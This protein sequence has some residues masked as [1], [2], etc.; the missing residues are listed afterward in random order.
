M[1]NTTQLPL[2]NLS[3]ITATPSA[4]KALQQT[5]LSANTLLARHHCGDW[6]DLCTEDLARNNDALTSGSRLFSAYQVTDTFKI[7][8]ITEADQSAITS[9]CNIV[10][11]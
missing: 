1:K 10:M 2:F 9:I 8:V 5:G 3:Q 6:G 11:L 4:I 7:W